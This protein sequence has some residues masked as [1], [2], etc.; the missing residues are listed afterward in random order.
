MTI[1]ILLCGDVPS[2]LVD[3]F[4]CYTD[5]LKSQ[6]NLERYGEVKVWNVYQQHQLPED[7]YEC[8]AYVIGGSPSG[9]N[10][11]LVWL[12]HLIIFIRQAFLANRKL[13]GICFGHQIINHA[14]GGEVQR[15]SQGWGL[16]SYHVQLKQNIDELNAG[17]N[18]KLISIHQDQVVKP[19]NKFAVMAGNQFCPNYITRYKDQVLT[20][21]G[22]P[23][24]NGP[25]FNALLE[26]RTD[27]FNEEQRHK[28]KINDK[29]S[30]LFSTIFNQF[31]HQFLFN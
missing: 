28:A 11:N 4:G 29:K 18:M 12:H 3:E 13:F 23:E 5:C 21:Q 31:A 10:D 1:G 17:Q 26:Q 22:H 7:A 19:A 8:E 30:M 14:L 9:V 25:F 6:L 27:Q 16:G 2:E 24:F 15:A 20:V